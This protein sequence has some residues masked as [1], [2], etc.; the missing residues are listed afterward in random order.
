[1]AILKTDPRVKWWVSAEELSASSSA[2]AHT[3]AGAVGGVANN[4]N[5]QD[6]PVGGLVDGNGNIVIKRVADPTDA[7]RWCYQMRHGSGW[8]LWNG[9]GKTEILSSGN[10]ADG[11]SYM[12]PQQVWFA[13][14]WC[15][16][17]DATDGGNVFDFHNSD[18]SPS[19]GTMI[20][21]SAINGFHYGVGS[22]WGVNFSYNDHAA[23]VN[24]DRITRTASMGRLNALE[25]NFLIG[26]FKASSDPA[27][28]P[29]VRLW[30]RQ[31]NGTLQLK[32]ESQLPIGYKYHDLNQYQKFGVYL[33]AISHT[34]TQYYRGF[35]ILNDT[36]GTPTITADEMLTVFGGTPG[37][38]GSGG[39]PPVTDPTPPTSGPAGTSIVGWATLGSGGNVGWN[40]TAGLT[41]S[42]NAP[43][44][45]LQAYAILAPGAANG[46]NPNANG[47]DF[48][49][50]P[51]LITNGASV[52]G[53][54]ALPDQYMIKA[55]IHRKAL[56]STN[57]SGIV[58]RNEP[59]ETLEV[60]TELF[61]FE[62][63]N[64]SASLVDNKAELI[65]PVP[66]GTLI[67]GFN[68][69]KIYL[70]AGTKTTPIFD[71]VVY[72]VT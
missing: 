54:S 3:H 29:F 6:I 51:T 23:T 41:V 61:S 35:V 71:A 11:Q 70:K 26:Q 24:D 39:S 22:S 31:G 1:M 5:I 36:A 67:G 72:P 69:V 65:I 49:I 45:G 10:G 15:V 68:T 19:Q 60:G 66:A 47:Y 32:Y 64:L 30:A 25:W 37:S 63:L 20:A 55:Y 38:G 33:G 8:P 57:V 17:S 53:E 48:S 2:I 28:G 56:G 9:L 16:A 42:G 21:Y 44:A 18:T 12:I 27:Q 13:L 59:T 58:W 52:V 4:V 14:E 62:G 46:G 40:T 34:Q 50:S 43:G 7:T